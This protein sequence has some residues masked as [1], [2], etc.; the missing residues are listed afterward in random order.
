[1]PYVAYYV[2][3]IV[4]FAPCHAA[5]CLRADDATLLLLTLRFRLA[6]IT[7]RLPPLPLPCRH[8]LIFVVTGRLHCC[9]FSMLLMLS[10]LLMLAFAFFRF[11]SAAAAA[12]FA[13]AAIADAFL[14]PPL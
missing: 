10:P 7:S 4:L 9:R 13:D 8:A 1:M 6:V 14:M 2:T 5:I 3:I 12:C 11:L